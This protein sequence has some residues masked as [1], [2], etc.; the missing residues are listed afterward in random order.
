MRVSECDVTKS[1][2]DKLLGIKFN[3]KLTFA[4]HI[5][6]VCSKASRKICALAK[7]G[8]YMDLFKRRILIHT[9]FNYQF[10]Y[11]PL[12][13]MCH[14]GTTNQK[15]NKLHE[16]SIHI[17][18]KG[19]QSSLGK[20]VYIHIYTHT[21]NTHTHTHTHTLYGIENEYHI[22]RQIPLRTHD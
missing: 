13:Q 3:V 8:P 9:F 15:I 11:Y 1:E 19:K 16:R 2:Q 6:D 12:I 10:S 21:S 7:V 18:Y 14:N 20:H 4:N 5:T 22:Y 17:I